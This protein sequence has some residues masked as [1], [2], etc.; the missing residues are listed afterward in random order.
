MLVTGLLLSTLKRF[1]LFR[2]WKKILLKLTGNFN[3]K[4]TEK[5]KKKKKACE[6][7][8]FSSLFA[9]EKVSRGITSA[10]RRQKFD[11]EKRKT[12][13]EK[14]GEGRGREKSAKEGKR[15]GSPYRLFPIPLFF[16]FL[17]IPYLYRRL[18]RG[19]H[20]DP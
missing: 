2:K 10:T 1:C 9:A 4:K 19:L 15:E 16:P 3:F 18:L 12:D 8:C 20:V 17:P 14:R 11:Q 7:N 6:N 5:C 13:V